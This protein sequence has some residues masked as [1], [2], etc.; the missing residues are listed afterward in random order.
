VTQVNSDRPDT[1]ASADLDRCAPLTWAQENYWYIY[2]VPRPVVD[3]VKVARVFE[4][5]EC[6]VGQVVSALA[7]L[8][9]GYES[10]R[11]V[12]PVGSDGRPVQL[13]LESP[14]VEPLIVER[15][16]DDT[17]RRLITRLAKDRMDPMVDLPIKA[18]VITSNTIPRQLA[19]LF[20]HI[21]VDAR[22]FEPLERGLAMLL[23]GEVEEFRRYAAASRQPSESANIE[24]SDDQRAYHA[25]TLDYLSKA[26]CNVP[27]VQFPAFRPLSD[28]PRSITTSSVTYIR[29]EMLSPRLTRAIIGLSKRERSQPGTLL[30]F[31]CAIAITALSA[32]PR[33]AVRV[34]V[35]SRG[36]PETDSAVGTM[37]QPALIWVDLDRG[38][39]GKQALKHIVRS[40]LNAYRHARHSYFALREE[41]SR[42]ARARGIN[43][44]QAVTLDARTVVDGSNVVLEPEATDETTIAWPECDWH[45][46]YNDVF[47]SG[48]VN[49][50]TYLGLTMHRSIGDESVVEQILR[51]LECLLLSWWQDPAVM[52]LSL[53]EIINQFEFPVTTYSSNW[54]YIDHSWINRDSLVQ[55]ISTI[56]GVR[57]VD[58]VEE[59]REGQPS[60]LA[61]V[62]ADAS[63]HLTADSIRSRLW[64]GLWDHCDIM[65]PQTIEV[66]TCPSAPAIERAPEQ[67]TEP[68]AEAEALLAAISKHVA[69]VVHDVEQTYVELGGSTSATRA[70]IDS[71]VATGY[72]GLHPDHLLGPFPIRTLATKLRKD[73]DAV[74]S[75]NPG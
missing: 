54:S 29:C 45:D 73:H 38:L 57:D 52:E 71:L 24:A 14:A 6:S 20:N 46:D 13:V 21:A 3:S 23:R 35:V 36:T 62:R 68:S 30:T 48:T 31:V 8:V 41:Q 70:V 12:Y 28:T 25:K 58:V 22:S 49:T 32:N 34:N 75:P 33:C 27:A 18:G 55:V 47:L 50:I 16:D 56:P 19:L 17:E 65:V 26:L 60:L 15:E 37:F 61:R 10:L 59:D 40:S 51:S 9:E 7:E 53:G 44:R 5:P 63:A 69:D 43:F 2:R 11:T 39:S 74:C 42:V 4:L 1:P 64:D 66:D 72:H 67:T